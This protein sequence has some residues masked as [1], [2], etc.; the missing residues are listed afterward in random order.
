MGMEGSRTVCGQWEVLNV[1][2]P[3]SSRLDTGVS[4]A[5]KATHTWRS[6]CQAYTPAVVYPSRKIPGT[7]LCYSL[8]QPESHSAAGRVR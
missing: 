2:S 3:P 1:T 8:S 5:L 6:G 7:H 4:T